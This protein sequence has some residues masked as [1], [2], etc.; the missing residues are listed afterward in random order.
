[1]KEV[2]NVYQILARK[3]EGNSP[4]RRP[5]HRWED[6]IKVDLSQTELSGLDS[7]SSG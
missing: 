1:M 6:Y 7:S 5:R 2:I 3:P 4:L